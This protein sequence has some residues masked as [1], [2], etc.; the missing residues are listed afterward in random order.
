MSKF[1]MMVGLPKSGKSI[2]AERLKRSAD[3]TTVIISPDITRMQILEAAKSDSV[4]DS[5]V[6]NHML[7]KTKELLKEG[8]DVIFDDSNV[9]RS[10]REYVLASLPPDCLKIAV[11]VWSRYETCLLRDDNGSAGRERIREH[12]LKFQ[13]P[14]YDEGWDK[15]QSRYTSDFYNISEYQSMLDCPHDNPHHPNTVG[16][17]TQN[18]CEVA[19]SFVQKFLEENL[20]ELHVKALLV[21]F[22]A[23]LHDV[24]KKLTKS[25]INSRGETTS[26]AHYYGHHNVSGYF[27]L[28]YE[29]LKN[30]KM[31]MEEQ[32]LI[33]WL[34]NVHMEPHLQSK[35]Y[36]NMD[37]KYKQLVDLLYY[38]DKKG[39]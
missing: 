30:S 28:G 36:K 1:I 34:V 12:L 14:F 6:F 3:S 24:G 25:F 13:I 15:I 29:P 17:H 9:T 5:K 11:V 4:S 20:V 19:A 18:V 27:A 31:S 22:A 2:I 38:C 23:A 37:P 26:V 7:N 33:C 35:Y 8:V 16:E 32:L 21:L 39:A 10:R